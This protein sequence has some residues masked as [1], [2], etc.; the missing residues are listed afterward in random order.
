MDE[1]TPTTRKRVHRIFHIPKRY[2]MPLAIIVI[3]ALGAAAFFGGRMSVYKAHPELTNAEQAE[4]ILAKVGKLIKLPEGETPS[5]ATIE[6]AASVKAGQPFLVNAEN[7]DV[8]IV[9]SA[10]ATAI[11]YRPSA[12]QL[13]AVGPVDT[14]APQQEQVVETAPETDAADTD[15]SAET[16][17]DA[18]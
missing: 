8:L 12:D 15:A 11:L 4:A 7:G 16:E 1:Q 18:E 14:S 5:M 10:A 3:I 13:I 17:T 6:D 2:I 9:Y